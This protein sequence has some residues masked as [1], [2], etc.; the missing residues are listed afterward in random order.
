MYSCCVFSVNS[1]KP[2]FKLFN[3]YGNLATFVVRTCD[4][5][6]HPKVVRYFFIYLGLFKN[7]FVFDI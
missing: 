4:P 1:S 3:H 7:L 5:T 6:I 2:C